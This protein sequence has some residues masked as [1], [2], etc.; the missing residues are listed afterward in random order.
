ME[1]TIDTIDE[2]KL[3]HPTFLLFLVSWTPLR[4]FTKNTLTFSS[5]LFWY[6][7]SSITASTIAMMINKQKKGAA[8]PIDHRMT[9]LLFMGFWYAIQAC[10]YE[11]C[12]GGHVP[13]LF[14]KTMKL[15]FMWFLT[16]Y[17]CKKLENPWFKHVFR[18]LNE[19]ISILYILFYETN[20]V[21]TGTFLPKFKKKLRRNRG[22]PFQAQYDNFKK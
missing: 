15:P 3:R 22:L 17:H 13:V 16:P 9:R 12:F 5:L 1:E 11:G 20:F 21:W 6:V 4:N 2:N 14:L 8:T 19:V 18:I 7:L 10:N